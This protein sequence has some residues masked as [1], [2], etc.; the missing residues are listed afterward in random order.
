MRKE[1]KKKEMEMMIKRKG[2]IRGKI[3]LVAVLLIVILSMILSTGF[4]NALNR[5][6]DNDKC[7]WI[8]QLYGKCGQENK[9]IERGLQEK[10][11]QE[12]QTQQEGFLAAIKSFF[13]LKWLLDLGLD[14][15]E[16]LYNRLL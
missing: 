3:I 1:M 15:G 11:S 10:L 9:E 16:S 13:S 2:E 14:G 8:E 5:G 6:Y 7:T 12:Q 4:V